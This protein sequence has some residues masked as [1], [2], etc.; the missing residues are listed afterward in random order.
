M[1]SSEKP[2]AQIKEIKR[3]MHELAISCG[4][5]GHMDAVTPLEQAYS[6]LDEVEQIIYDKQEI[7]D[8]I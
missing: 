4:K 2:R 3:L 6:E 1:K 5:L 8:N 7:H